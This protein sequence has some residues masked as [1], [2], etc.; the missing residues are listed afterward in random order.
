MIRIDANVSRFG[1][2]RIQAIEVFATI[3][4]IRGRPVSDIGMDDAG[5]CWGKSRGLRPRG[6]RGVRRKPLHLCRRSSLG[7]CATCGKQVHAPARSARLAVS[8]WMGQDRWRKAN[9]A[10]IAEPSNPEY[11]KK[12]VVQ[13]AGN[14][15]KRIQGGCYT[16][17]A[18]LVEETLRVEGSGGRLP[19]TVLCAKTVLGSLNEKRRTR[20]AERIC[21]LCED[22][23]SDDYLNGIRNSNVRLSAVLSAC[24]TVWVRFE[25]YLRH[26]RVQLDTP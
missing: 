19:R 11:S 17:Q 5:W 7:G 16:V 26:N 25:G 18:V 22:R 1:V 23:L 3:R 8:D 6:L 4:V 24:V 21:A 13:W 12:V 2:T 10:A 14:G 9:K 20:N 15:K